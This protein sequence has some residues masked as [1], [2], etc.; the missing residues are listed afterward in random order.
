MRT[1]LDRDRVTRLTEQFPELFIAVG[2]N[3]SIGNG[4]LSIIEW[5]C[6]AL[7]PLVKS[8]SDVC[9]HCDRPKQDHPVMMEQTQLFVRVRTAAGLDAVKL[10]EALDGKFVTQCVDF[11]PCKPHFMQ[12]KQKFGGLRVYMSTH[13]PEISAILREVESR[14]SS[15]CEECGAG[16]ATQMTIS[17]WRTTLCSSC[18]ILIRADREGWKIAVMG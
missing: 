16:G 18:E 5:M 14:A 15:T 4:W 2:P 8:A 12:I 1:M 13:T 17:G 6:E 7:Q 10:N 11:T 9:L 3:I